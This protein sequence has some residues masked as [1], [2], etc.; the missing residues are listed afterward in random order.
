MKT[1]KQAYS[2]QYIL[3]DIRMYVSVKNNI[4]PSRNLVDI[5]RMTCGMLVCVNSN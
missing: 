2:A 4:L 3:S 5:P 1:E